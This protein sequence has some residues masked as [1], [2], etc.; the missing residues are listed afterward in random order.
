MVRLFVQLVYGG[1]SQWTQAHTPN[2]YILLGCNAER[3]FP[4]K[5]PHS[6]W[7]GAHGSPQEA[8]IQAT[9]LHC[10]D[11]TRALRVN[12]RLSKMELGFRGHSLSFTTREGLFICPLAPA[13]EKSRPASGC[14][15]CTSWGPRGGQ[16]FGVSCGP[17]QFWA[18]SREGLFQQHLELRSCTRQE[19]PLLV[20]HGKAGTT[21]AGLPKCVWLYVALT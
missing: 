11:L 15:Q 12:S 16:S 10:P 21:Q 14:L 18:G 9:G 17:N 5:L 19:Q 2:V 4:L 8:V 20:V 1:S 6:L 3:S 7:F 13:G